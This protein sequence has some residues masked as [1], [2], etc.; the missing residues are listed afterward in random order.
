MI[1]WSGSTRT[2]AI[3]DPA[4]NGWTRWLSPVGSPG[5]REAPT[6]VWVGG[7]MIVWGGVWYFG[8]WD[9]SP[10]GGVYDPESDIWTETAGNRAPKGRW[11]HSAVST[12]SK[13]IVWG[14]WLAN[15][16][17]I[18]TGGVY[19][20]VANSWTATATEGAPSPRAGHVA[21]WTGSKMIVWGG[22][23]PG[24]GVFDPVTNSWRPV[25]NAGA[26]P[27]TGDAV[28][29]WT[30]S[31][32]VVWGGLLRNGVSIDSGGLYDPLSD[33][34]TAM[35]QA[36]APSPRGYAIAVWTGTRMVV[37]GGLTGAMGPT[38]GDGRIY[39]PTNDRWSEIVAAG[40][41]EPR[42][43]HSA[44]WTGSTMVVWGGHTMDTSGMPSGYFNTGGIYDDPA[45]LR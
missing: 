23:E 15:S 4:A 9:A 13:M 35:T 33:T 45:L 14:G 11:L 18:D 44:V 6:V 38:L 5:E 32:M 1:V 3:F 28:A 21:V 39:D 31:K 22:T 29:V 42:T 26:P 34:W 27:A 43:E 10:I 36:G 2:G 12:G 41:P 8:W 17:A 20:P 40:A 30:G 7:R 19:D 16:N 25:S 37:W 24:G